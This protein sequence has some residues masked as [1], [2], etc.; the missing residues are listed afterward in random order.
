MH[1]LDLGMTAYFL[2]GVLK[3]LV[4]MGSGGT[5][6]SRLFSI[7]ERI[8][9]IY[10]E[11]N[12]DA[13]FSEITID[14][15]G[16]RDQTFPCLKGKAIENKR[17][18]PV[19]AKLWSEMRST[20]SDEI[21]QHIARAFQHLQGM[22]AVYDS[23]GIFLSSSAAA[24]LRDEGQKFSLHYNYCANH[25]IDIGHL[26]FNVPI[27]MHVLQHILEEATF[28]SPRATACYRFEDMVGRLVK[29][30]GSCVNGTPMKLIGPKV[31]E[32]YRVALGV[33]W[34]GQA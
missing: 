19:L 3:I 10:D 5:Q 31:V 20:S 2:G 16:G 33:R 13:R 18:V 24:A 23:G 34:S 4:M 7:V 29:V 1:T 28:L 14:M 30:A 11:L 21:D 25:Y 8:G 26:V 15:F 12:I 22:Y 6:A 27:K 9:A 32:N 17:L